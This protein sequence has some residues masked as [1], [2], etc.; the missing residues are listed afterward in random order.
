MDKSVFYKYSAL[1]LIGFLLIYGLCMELKIPMP[2][3]V[4]SGCTYTLNGVTT[5][6][7][8][9]TVFCDHGYRAKCID[10]DIEE[11]ITWGD[12]YA[13]C[14][15][16]SELPSE[17]CYYS[18]TISNSRVEPYTLYWPKSFIGYSVSEP[19]ALVG[20]PKPYPCN[21][22]LTSG[23]MVC[24]KRTNTL[25]MCGTGKYSGYTFTSTG[26]ACSTSKICTPY[27]KRCVYAHGMA[28]YPSGRDIGF[29]VAVETCNPTGTGW[30]IST[31]CREGCIDGECSTMTE[32][33]SG[34]DCSTFNMVYDNYCKNGDV[35]GVEVYWTPGYHIDNGYRDWDCV[36]D[37]QNI[38][39]LNKEVMIEDCSRTCRAQD[40]Y[41]LKAQCIAQTTTTTTTTTTTL[42][43]SCV[44]DGCGD[45]C[46]NNCLN[47]GNLNQCSASAVYTCINTCPTCG[48][49]TTLPVTTMGYQTC[50][51]IGQSQN[52]TLYDTAPIGYICQGQY[53]AQA[54]K[55]CYY[56]CQLTTTTTQMGCG[57]K[58]LQMGYSW[59]MCAEKPVN[60]G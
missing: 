59:G 6:I 19:S 39:G 43:A 34:T 12:N 36:P 51:A 23:D 5:V 38:L 54:G 21:T 30:Y 31:S 15:A 60:R 28:T 18:N 27:E 1:A 17:M 22:Y 40:Y 57:T 52:I 55:T 8:H 50:A 16:W 44:I 29:G 53:Y 26:A 3:S 2:F 20:D 32:V 14:C 48:A 45:A 9:D 25:L 35:Y 42:A 56:A 49:G 58:C 4:Y 33:N 13:P 10:G 11:K 7:P 41:S 46:R 37:T 24:D 47:Q